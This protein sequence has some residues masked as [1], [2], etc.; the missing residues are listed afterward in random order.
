MNRRCLLDFLSGLLKLNPFERW[1]PQQAKMHP[2]VTGDEFTVPF[3]PKFGQQQEVQQKYRQIHPTSLQ[4]SNK[5]SEIAANQQVPVYS[6]FNEPISPEKIINN[7]IIITEPISPYATKTGRPRANTMIQTI[8]PHLQKIVTIQQ[9]SGP[10]K[11]SLRNAAAVTPLPHL[12]SNNSHAPRVI[13]TSLNNDDVVYSS[14][15]MK[16]I[17]VSNTLSDEISTIDTD[18]NL[19][20]TLSFSINQ[21]GLQGID[22]TSA[23]NFYGRHFSLRKAVS[24]TI[25]HPHHHYHQHSHHNSPHQ[26]HKQILN[27]T[28]SGGGGF[29]IPP[30]LS[31]N[32]QIA[33][34]LNGLG[35]QNGSDGRDLPFFEGSH[36]PLELL[37]NMN[38]RDTLEIGSQHHLPMGERGER[39]IG[40]SR[41]PSLP[42]LQEFKLFSGDGSQSGGSDVRF[43][44]MESRKGSS[45]DVHLQFEAV[46]LEQQQQQIPQ[47]TL[48]EQRRMS[49]SDGFGNNSPLHR[50]YNMPQQQ[51]SQQQSYMQAGY[52]FPPIQSQPP[53]LHQ[54]SSSPRNVFSGSPR[55]SFPQH[56]PSYL[57]QPV[58]S[59]QTSL[60]SS[61]QYLNHNGIGQSGLGLYEVNAGALSHEASITAI[62]DFRGRSMSL[63][64][65]TVYPVNQP[66]N[67]P[68]SS[69]QSMKTSQQQQQ[70][71]STGSSSGGIDK[72]RPPSIS[73]GINMTQ[74]PQLQ[75]SHY[76]HHQAATAAS[77]LHPYSAGYQLN[78]ASA[79]D[80]TG[81][82]PQRINHPVTLRMRRQ[83]VVQQQQQQQQ[84]QLY[85]STPPMNSNSASVSSSFFHGSIGIPF[86]H[87]SRI[88]GGGVSD[89]GYGSIGSA[90]A[91]F[92]NHVPVAVGSLPH[93][94]E[95]RSVNLMNSFPSAPVLA[96][97]LMND[98]LGCGGD[99]GGVDGKSWIS[100]E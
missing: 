29:D 83:S 30:L 62:A 18:R 60:S 47:Q 20:R 55:N 64:M 44:G 85:G 74:P 2:F 33:E 89:G 19:Y 16:T 28:N 4:L 56:Q 65:S 80:L 1:S 48:Y 54:Y 27:E 42:G 75:N 96:G 11:V 67:H 66:W 58:L 92:A 23:E 88:G 53:Q 5:F 43:N 25:S 24:D 79:N 51:T 21:Q 49:I 73:T 57:Q 50:Q 14:P 97:T 72:K 13:N 22:S 77:V 9:Q 84:Q 37:H 98:S 99:D 71:Q 90:G 100:S 70:Q 94:H 8:P 91:E 81:I 10:N 7:E 35:G 12:S 68:A 36:L 93:E 46:S 34:S 17:P 39:K 86:S 78:S 52:A 63:S 69:I 59:P 45:D 40:P 61:S 31:P 26:H 6:A 38:F 41:V 3:T 87:Y 15:D 32:Y 95:I 76:Q 82:P